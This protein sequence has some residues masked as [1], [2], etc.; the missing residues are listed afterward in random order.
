MFSRV[1]YDIVCTIRLHNLIIVLIQ[2][3]VNDVDAFLEVLD[4]VGADEEEITILSDWYRWIEDEVLYT[5]NVVNQNPA[6]YHVEM[7]NGVA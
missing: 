7:L 2:P 3:T 5:R 4:E 1:I 6:K